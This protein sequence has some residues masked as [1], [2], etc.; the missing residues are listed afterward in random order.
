MPTPPP[1]GPEKR[2]QFWEPLF[3]MEGKKLSNTIFQHQE[4]IEH[5]IRVTM[6]TVQFAFYL[7]FRGEKLKVIHRAARWHDAGKALLPKWLLRKKNLTDEEWR[8]IKC[9]SELGENIINFFGLCGKSAKIVRAHHEK[10][11]GS[12]YPDGLRGYE[13]PE[14]ARILTLIDVYDAITY[15]RAYREYTYSHGAALELILSGKGTQF[16]PYYTVQFLAFISQ[17]NRAIG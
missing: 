16:D 9:H 11:D 13:I 7:G 8:I 10:W 6:Y 4:V 1:E 5:S 17:Y 15:Q 12:G 3:N 14:G 2:K